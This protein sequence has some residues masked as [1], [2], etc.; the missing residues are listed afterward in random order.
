VIGFDP[1]VFPKARPA[2]IHLASGFG[3]PSGIT[4]DGTGA[5]VL[6]D[7]GGEV[8]E[9]LHL[10][11][12][13]VIRGL[14][15]TGFADAGIY[16]DGADNTIASNVVSG[17]GEQGIA[18]L[19]PDNWLVGN[20]VG[21]DPSGSQIWGAQQVGLFVADSGNIIGGPDLADRNVI[22]GN[23]LEIFLKEARG[24]TIQGNYVGTD[25]SGG[26]A[27]RP[28]DAEAAIGVWVGSAENRI[29]G[30]VIAGGINVLDPGS[31]YNAIVGNLIGVDA[32][33]HR[34]LEGGGDII[35]SEPFNQV[36]GAV[37]GEGNVVSGG[38]TIAATDIVTLGNRVGVDA[39]GHPLGDDASIMAVEQR[40][41]IGGRSPNAANIVVGGGIE[42]RSDS[43]V[44]IGN[45]IG[46]RELEEAIGIQIA[47]AGRNHVVANHIE[48]E[49][50]IGIRL[51]E[52]AYAN[53]VRGNF[54]RRNHV[55]LL[56]DSSSERNVVT[57]N[58]FES[59]RSQ[60]RDAGRA[61]VWDDG[62]GGNFWGNLDGRDAN[63]DGVFDRSISVPPNGVDRYPLAQSP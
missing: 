29:A 18:V 22:S 31:S 58:A 63:G 57:G 27:L 33:G 52:G 38:I 19:G 39:S 30:N 53:V 9:G 40:A 4:V 5:G 12:Q 23:R 20:V 17:N 43:N 37:L 6:L 10:D 36:G 46:R 62:R 32:A 15:V 50:G 45:R 42:I 14:T 28:A 16:V 51:S 48:T 8:K 41:I 61:N 21:L 24:T 55:G 26:V 1:T 44:L 35:I 47:N 3:V 11:S 56:A 34:R 59:N 7:G 54:V 60:A 13:T 49:A 25:V 2:T